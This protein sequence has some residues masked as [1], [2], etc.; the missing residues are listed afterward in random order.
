MRIERNLN[1]DWRFCL[2]EDEKKNAATHS[3]AYQYAHAGSIWG[4][5]GVNFDD[6]DW[7]VVQLPHD[8]ANEM[9]FGPENMCSHG[10]LAASNAWY[11][12]R[13]LLPEEYRGKHL[14]LTFG[15]VAM[16]ARVYLNGSLMARSFSAYTPIYIDITDRAYYGERVNTLVVEVD[17]YSLEGWFYEGAGIYRDVKLTVKNMLHLTKDGVF[18]KPVRDENGN[19]SV[20][21]E[22]MVDNGDLVKDGPGVF[23]V[24]TEILDGDELVA[25]AVSAV[26]TCAGGDG[27]TVSGVI[28]LDGYTPHLWDIDDPHLYTA[29][30]QIRSADDPA[31]VLDEEEHRIGFRTFTADSRRGFFLNGRP[32]KLKG[33]CNHQDHAGV[34]AAVPDSVHEYRIARLKELGSNAYRCSHNMPTEVL[35]DICDRVGMLVIDENRHFESGEEGVWQME[36]MVR[37]GRNHPSVVMYSLFNEEA[38]QA[39]A[40]GCHIYRRLR[41]TLRKWDDS[42][43]IFG[44]MGGGVMDPGGTAPLMDVTGVNY[45]LDIAAQFHEKYPDQPVFGSENHSA[46]STRGCYKTDRDRH[47]CA[48]YDEDPSGWGQT[49]R[50]TWRFTTE[51]DWYGGICIWTGFDYRGEPTPYTWPSVSSQFGLMDTCGFPKAA[52]WQN[53]VCFTDEPLTVLIPHWNHRPGEMVRVMAVTN[54]EEAELWVNGTSLGRNPAGSCDPAQWEIPFVPGQIEAAGYRNGVQAGEICR[55]RTAG[56]PKKIMAV[57]HRGWIADDGRD[58]VLLNCS[59]TDENGIEV[60]TADNLLCFTIEGDGVLLGVGNGDPNSH[61]SDHLPKRRL[62]AGHAQAVIGALPGAESVRITVEGEGLESAVLELELRHAVMPDYLTSVDSRAIHGATVS[63]RS[64]PEKPD[65]LQEIPDYDMNTMENIVFD[66]Y[67]LKPIFTEGW[68]LCRVP[69][70]VPKTLQ[71]GQMCCIRVLR[72]VA[73][74]LVAALNGKII[75]DNP[76]EIHGDGSMCINF[77]GTPG[78]QCELRL[79]M[80]GTGTASGICGGFEVF[81]TN[82]GSVSG[83]TSG[84]DGKPVGNE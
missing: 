84:S 23:T 44:A 38:L 76:E 42:R 1:R 14:L 4:I 31:E 81:T 28:R 29:R 17:G 61:E 66:T 53:K 26:Q 41:H 75:L 72:L 33:T 45:S 15:G 22:A 30:V 20:H 52:F 74:G 69:F 82:K 32:I 36:A 78:Q 24:Q 71:K 35:L 3:E 48:S 68:R 27:I 18:V 62:F 54:C 47:V 79:L 40:E 80:E 9:E 65:I 57:P 63:V 55:I 43:L 51:N 12:K 77:S 8:Y 56:A 19:W 50:E 34:G 21:W 70:T 83:M 10:Y 67:S 59:V 6:S 37:Q 2:G 49:I 11:R 58:A 64:F 5:A 7:R 16:K 60:P 25:G 39:T 73:K 46:Y 13:F